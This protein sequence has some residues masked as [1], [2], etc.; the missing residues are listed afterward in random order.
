MNNLLVVFLLSLS[1]LAGWAQDKKTTEAIVEKYT[2]DDGTKALRVG[3]K[4]TVRD[5]AGAE[6]VS[7]Q[8]PT[9]AQFRKL[10]KDMPSIAP[11]LKEAFEVNVDPDVTLRGMNPN[12]KLNV[13]FREDVLT[14]IA[15]SFNKSVFKSEKPTGQSIP[16]GGVPQSSLPSF[17]GGNSSRNGHEKFVDANK[18]K[19][20]KSRKD[21]DLKG[22]A[23]QS[24]DMQSL[25]DA[26]A[27]LIAD[28]RCGFVRAKT[29]QTYVT[30]GL[31][32][33]KPNPIEID[34]SGSDIGGGD[35][36]VFFPEADGKEPVTL[37][38]DAEHFN[39]MSV[40]DWLYGHPNG[41][42]N[43]HTGFYAQLTKLGLCGGQAAGGGQ[44]AAGRAGEFD[45]GQLRQADRKQIDTEKLEKLMERKDT[46]LKGSAA[47]QE[48]IKTL[49][50]AVAIVLSDKR[51][52]FKRVES[53][54]D[55]QTKG[56]GIAEP[57]PIKLDP[58]S[59]DIGGGRLQFYPENKGEPVILGWDA[60]HFSKMSVKDWLYGSPTGA[61]N[62]H[63][64][65][66]RQ[67]ATKKL[68][69]LNAGGYPHGV[70]D[71]NTDTP[72]HK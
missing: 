40:Q 60:N 13:S 28:K 8:T 35:L 22:S 20:L 56:I 27:T 63:V 31:G 44:A 54:Q 46:D 19:E 4:I 64:G 36:Q 17:S 1:C 47:G 61:T 11:V 57:E 39:E 67:L 65:L 48:D 59:T 62:G 18:L 72:T 71:D 23:A 41:A 7:Y 58:N 33:A 69:G 26:L 45:L 32:P 10:L 29:K 49:Y 70:Q 5:S 50:D 68:C 9:V 14:K 16:A 52:G 34:P 42:S 55:Y 25:Y 2:Q 37:H 3:L 38:W 51:C 53:K 43:G 6:S 24:K 66:Y 15:D 12:E 30:K 21:T